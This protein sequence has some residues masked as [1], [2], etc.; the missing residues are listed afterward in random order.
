MQVVKNEGIS[1]SLTKN[2]RNKKY[3]VSFV[4][5]D[6]MD[7]KRDVMISLLQALERGDKYAVLNGSVIMLNTIT[8]IDPVITGYDDCFT[9]KEIEGVK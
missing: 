5:H 1:Q 2:M 3:M 6:S 4:K 7:I 8:S 9:E